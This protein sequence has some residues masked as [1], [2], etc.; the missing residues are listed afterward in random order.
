[1]KLIYLDR[2][3]VQ[4]KMLFPFGAGEWTS[5]EVK[6]LPNNK[7]ELLLKKFGG[8]IVPYEDKPKKKKQ[9]P[10]PKPPV[11]TEVSEVS[12]VTKVNEVTYAV[13]QIEDH[14]KID[15]GGEN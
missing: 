13:E 6:D 15:G 7:A 9:T 5:G 10:P 4:S 1:M 11:E 14:Y 3:G 2:D 8:I 12:E